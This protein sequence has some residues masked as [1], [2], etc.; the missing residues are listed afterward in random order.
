MD[1]SLTSRELSIA[2]PISV[3]VLILSSWSSQ[4][5]E[6]RQILRDSSLKLLSSGSEKI[7]ITYRFIIGQAPTAQIQMTMGPQLVQESAGYHDILV[8]PAS[9]APEHKSHK[10]F[11][12]LQWS[13]D[14]KYDYVVK[15]DD[16]VF[17]RWDTLASEIASLGPKPYYWKGLT[18]RNM[19]TDS[20]HADKSMSS[21][22]GLSILPPFTS[23]TLYTVSRDVADLIITSKVPRRFVAAEDHNLAVWLF[24]FD[25]QPIHDARIQDRDVCEEDQIA[26]RFQPSD[27]HHMKRMYANIVSGRSQ[28]DGFDSSACAVCYPCH[29]KKND[30]R[31]SNLACDTFR[32]ITLREQSNVVKVPNMDV[33]DT[34]PTMK[35]GEGDDWIIKDVLSKRTSV[36]SDTDDWNLLYWVCWSS[37]PSTFT[38]RHWR[39]LEL[40]WIHEPRAVI[41]MISNTLP[42]NFFE[43]YSQHGYKIHVVHF[44]KQN[45]LD[46]KWHFG[47]G[48]QDWIEDWERWDKGGYFNWHLTDYIR[49]FLLYNYGGTY[50]DMDALWIRVSPDPHLEFIGSDYATVE[51][52]L[53]WT[54]DDEGLY[55]PQ[56]VMRF[57]RGWRFFR[58]IAESAFSSYT[59]DPECFNCH[60]P[61]A[62]TTYIRGHR[63]AV[64]ANGFTI[65]PREVLYPAGYQEVNKFFA[66]NPLAEQELKSKLIVSSWNIHLFGKMTNHLDIKFGSVIDLLFKRFD[67][68][69]PHRD[70]QTRSIISSTNTWMVPLQLVTPRTYIYRAYTASI[71]KEHEKPWNDTSLGKFQG[72]DVIYVRGGPSICNLV[73][74]EAKVS[75]GTI[76]LDGSEEGNTSAGFEL[77][78]ASK[79]DVNALLNTLVYLPSPLLAANGGHDQLT[80]NVEYDNGEK[81]KSEKS[82]AQ[83]DIFVIETEEED[84]N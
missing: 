44:D 1:T 76:K 45:L 10:L 77:K 11:E 81:S 75:R 58:E 50:M 68:D 15:T 14:I 37:A 41:F 20:K 47:S 67:L 3:V 24:G 63:Q 65:L 56:G 18:Y 54:L 6:R 79:K 40:V 42:E 25:V 69:I 64:E 22:Y 32:G 5:F 16:D 2:A 83:V 21:D 71:P 39:A 7:S 55:L 57:K 8:V 62:I 66:P 74:V 84:E 43:E 36:Y 52:D 26:K 78:N 60:G 70:I 17:V 38:D 53:E 23:G 12:A 31:S 28:C 4:A 48:T 80:I 46:W 30:W 34:L 49:L 59:Y 19:P 51:S 27:V 61:K 9:D 13:K 72:L 33:K 82:S 73:K 35:I 29:G